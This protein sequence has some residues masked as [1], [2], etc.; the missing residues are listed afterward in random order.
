MKRRQ[1]NKISI[2]ASLMIVVIAI[3]WVWSSWNA[4]REKLQATAL[5]QTDRIETMYRSNL[6]HFGTFLTQMAAIIGNEADINDLFYQAKLAVER[7]G[8]GAGGAEAARLREAIYERYR[9]AWEAVSGNGDLRELHFQLPPATSFLRFHRPDLYGDDMTQ[10]RP[11]VLAANRQQTEAHG[12]EAGAA[13]G[14]IRGVVPVSHELEDGTTV[15]VGSVEVG[16]ALATLLNRMSEETG[17]NFAILADEGH[18]R[19]RFLPEIFA[20]W[21]RDAPAYGNFR[22]MASTDVT[23]ARSLMDE[24]GDHVLSERVPEVITEL[25]EQTI[26]LAKLPL[27]DYSGERDTSRPSVGFIYAWVPLDDAVLAYKRDV[28]E[29]LVIGIFVVFFLEAML[30]FALGQEQKLALQRK[31]SMTDALTGV[32]NRRH[33]DE[34]LDA[35]IRRAARSGHPV[36]VILAD[37]DYFK[38]YNDHYGHQAG[39]DCLRRVAIG[40]S[41]ELQRAGDFIARYGGEEFVVVLPDSSLSAGLAVAEKLRRAVEKLKIPHEKHPGGQKVTVSLGVAAGRVSQNDAKAL[42]AM[43]DEALYRAKGAGRNNSQGLRFGDDLDGG[44]PLP[45]L[46]R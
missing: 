16:M 33:F 25:A 20:L 3:F 10:T 21:T 29:A 30:F 24:L 7:E 37:V 40:M 31:A 19:S 14:G 43:A 42:V 15:H 32:S 44:Q 34:I 13:S 1:F 12:I 8:G 23:V 26:A 36:S 6:D 41:A 17:A 9:S 46:Y 4:A 28:A 27:R 18:L 5:D 35:E 11:M 39:D 2:S 22:L 45:L 38:R